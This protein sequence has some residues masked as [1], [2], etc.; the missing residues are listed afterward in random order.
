M[1]VVDE[2]FLVAS[3]VLKNLSSTAMLPFQCDALW[4][5]KDTIG[6]HISI[7]CWMG[8]SKRTKLVR[9][10][11][12]F[13][14]VGFTAGINCDTRCLKYQIRRD[15]VRIIVGLVHRRTVDA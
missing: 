2:H 7:R 4:R 1:L 15:S 5:R 6:F 3:D 11:G 12:V 10:L 13:E 8:N 14:H 9:S